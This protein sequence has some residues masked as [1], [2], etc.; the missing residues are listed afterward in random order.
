MLVMMMVVVV[1]VCLTVW[2]QLWPH[3][4][5]SSRLQRAVPDGSSGSS[6]ATQ[7]SEMCQMQ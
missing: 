1:V 5:A 4:P 6:K 7:K 2:L 3:N